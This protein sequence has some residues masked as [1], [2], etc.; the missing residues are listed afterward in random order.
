MQMNQPYVRVNPT[1]ATLTRVIGVRS[2]LFY[3]K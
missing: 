1:Y 3:K 2:A